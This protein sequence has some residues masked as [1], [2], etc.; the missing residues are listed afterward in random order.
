M[1]RAALFTAAGLLW[2]A[3]SVLALTDPGYTYPAYVGDW[4][5]VGIFSASLFLFDLAFPVLAQ[6]IGTRSIV[7]RSLVAAAGAVIAGVSNLLEDGLRL[8]WAFFGFILGTLVLEI[9]L[10]VFTIAVIRMRRGPTW[11]FAAVLVLRPP[12]QVEAP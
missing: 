11:L 7:R 3:I 1:V 2:A 4:F 9:G 12:T 5:K 6:V 8:D 10:I